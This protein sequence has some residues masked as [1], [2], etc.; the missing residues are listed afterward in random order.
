MTNT[1]TAKE[2]GWF[3]K[4]EKLKKVVGTEC[5]RPTLALINQLPACDE[6]IADM[7]Y[8]PVEYAKRNIIFPP[9]FRF[10]K[11]FLFAKN[12]LQTQ[13]PDLRGGKIN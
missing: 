13:L 3:L 5:H 1:F 9:H 8:G 7:N 10:T 4:L 6:H 2:Q 11:I 12:N